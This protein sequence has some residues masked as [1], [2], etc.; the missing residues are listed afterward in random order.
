MLLTVMV[1]YVF[2]LRSGSRFGPEQFKRIEEGMTEAEVES[3]LACPPG[4]Y[5]CYEWVNPTRFVSPSTPTA[6]YVM[7]SGRPLDELLELKNRS[8][9]EQRLSVAWRRWQGNQYAI[10]VVF[11]EDGRV[12]GHFLL[13]LVPSR[14][15]GFL[16]WLRYWTGL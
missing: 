12:I 15:A 7:Q 3:I 6:F 11:D 13:E 16:G 2:L 1:G 14:E 9:L 8:L 10:E 5:S 4:D